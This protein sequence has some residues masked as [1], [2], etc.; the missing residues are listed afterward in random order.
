MDKV[1]IVE[2]KSVSE[3]LQQLTEMGEDVSEYEKLYGYSIGQSEP[4]SALYRYSEY[5]Y[6]PTEEITNFMMG[7]A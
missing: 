2:S 7:G 5:D 3:Y 1:I 6:Q 4:Q